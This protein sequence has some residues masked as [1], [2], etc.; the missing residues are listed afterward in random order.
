MSYLSVVE[1]TE[2]SNLLGLVED[3][4]L[5]FELPHHT[6]LSEMLQK[7]SFGDGSGEGDGVVRQF[8]ILRGFLDEGKDTS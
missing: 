5:D 7:I 3:I 4:A 1:V 6:K 2:A 8:E